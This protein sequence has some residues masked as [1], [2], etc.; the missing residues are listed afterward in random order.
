MSILTLEIQPHTLTIYKFP[1]KTEIL[2][3][4]FTA[5]FFS[6]TRTT[7]ELSVVLS[8]DILLFAP[9][10][11][12]GWRA[13]KVRGQLDFS[14]VGIL[15]QL[16]TLLASGG[17]SIFAIST[18]DTDYILLKSEKLTLAIDVLQQAGYRI[19]NVPQN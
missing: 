13:L 11:E 3:E 17:I 18:F 4:I 10:I 1:P 14:L 6:I 5:E 2:S 8:D 12:K 7:D 15:A 19:I 16:S 9:H